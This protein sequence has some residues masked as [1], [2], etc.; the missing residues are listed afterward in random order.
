[1]TSW[2]VPVVLAIRASKAVAVLL[3]VNKVPI[4]VQPVN[5]EAADEKAARHSVLMTSNRS[6]I[7][8]FYFLLN[9]NLFFLYLSND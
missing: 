3:Q 5:G 1:M 8:S 9:K 4:S 7:L 2:Y 6:F